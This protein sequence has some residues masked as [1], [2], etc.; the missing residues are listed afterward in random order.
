[1]P[2]HV[3]H[4][5]HPEYLE[6]HIKGNRTVGKEIEETKAIVAEIF[7]LSANTSCTNLL[8]HADIPQRLPLSSQIDISMNIDVVGITKDHRI[9]LVAYNEEVFMSSKLIVGYLESIG[10]SVKLF[11]SKEKGRNWLLPKKRRSVILELFDS[12]KIF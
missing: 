1:M 10:Y 12:F 7:S 9:A 2:L 3:A 4:H 5:P 11:R 8:I 6:F